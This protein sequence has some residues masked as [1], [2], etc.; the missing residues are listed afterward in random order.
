MPKSKTTENYEISLIWIYHMVNVGSPMGSNC[1]NS[2]IMALSHGVHNPLCCSS[3]HENEDLG[4][5][6]LGEGDPLKSPHFG[7]ACAHP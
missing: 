3:E 6:H 1:P 7:K 5:E 2:K 4:G